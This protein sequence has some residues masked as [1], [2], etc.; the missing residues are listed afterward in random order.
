M[1]RPTIDSDNMAPGLSKGVS[2]NKRNVIFVVKDIQPALCD[3]LFFY[4][5]HVPRDFADAHTVRERFDRNLQSGRVF[6]FETVCGPVYL[7]GVPSVPPGVKA[8][9][10]ESKLVDLENIFGVSPLSRRYRDLLK[11]A[12]QWSLNVE[13]LDAQAEKL[14]TLF[15]SSE[16]LWLQ[17]AAKVQVSAM[18]LRLMATDVVN[19][20]IQALGQEFASM[21]AIVRK[22][23]RAVLDKC[24]MVFENVK[25]LPQRIAALKAAFAAC[26][27]RM[28][29]VVVDKCLMIREFAGTC[30]AS[31]NATMAA[32]CR[33]LPTGFMGSKVFDKLAFFKE[34][35]VKTVKNVAHA[36]E[37]VVGYS[38]IGN[39]R[40]T[41]VVIR[42]MRNDLTLLEQRADVLVEKEGWSA[43][44]D[45][46]LTYVFKSGDCYYAAPLAGNFVLNDVYC[47]ERVVLLSD[48][49]TPE[50]ND[51]LLLAALYT[52]STVADVL[53]ALKKGE[54]F[55][56][57][58]H[59]F[60]Y[61]KDATVSF[62]LAK[63]ASIADVLKLFVKEAADVWSVFNEKSHEFWTRAHNKCR[64]L[65]DLVATHCCKAQVTFVVLAIALGVTVWELVKQVLFKV[66]GLFTAVV[67]FCS[68]AWNGFCDQ[69]IHAKLFVNELGC[70]LVG[71]KNHCFQLLL[72][73]VHAFYKTL[74]KCAIGRIW[75]GDLLFWAG[76]AH[77]VEEDNGE[78]WFDAV[79]T[80]QVDEQG[81]VT[82]DNVP[83]FVVCHDVSIPERQKGYIVQVSADGKNYMFFRYQQGVNTYYA[84]MS[85]VGAVNVVCKAGGKTVT[86]GEN[87]V[88][89]LPTPD[90]KCIYLD[91]ECCGEP[92]TSVFKRVY[93]DPVEVET[94][95]T[96]E[97]LRAV[98]YEMMCDSLKLFPDAPK[99]PQ[100]GRAHV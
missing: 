83:D 66:A 40:G 44:F 15:S 67:D 100:I 99:P 14:D 20:V 60:V 94:S 3:A 18:A 76:G 78:V 77:K 43:V 85:Q 97:E 82:E 29:V 12:P 87:Q 98:V 61:V 70:V 45:G 79:D 62:T 19:L 49:Y 58:G 33:E 28:T 63:G 74:E 34:A 39:A 23:V 8:L 73:A 10:A 95:L 52:S 17:V 90:V 38:V 2:P 96:V 30:L 1:S 64:N 54:P 55:K 6:K 24:L 88:K 86:F 53:A 42:G 9:D 81:T 32:W 47:C 37:G 16:I 91:I 50:I 25:E 59:S 22:Q 46:K 11:T 7:Q 80:V 35:V 41:Q 26:V 56:F 13:S 92:W 69:L 51:G 4:T 72:V 93:K 57:L 36:P 31:V 71:V 48:G 89:E 65:K 75:A 27:K 68:K 84:P 21:F 5:S